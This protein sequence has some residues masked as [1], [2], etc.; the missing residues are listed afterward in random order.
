MS[1]LK[2][3]PTIG[4]V[5]LFGLAV[6]ASE[7]HPPSAR[8]VASAEA[9]ASKLGDLSSFRSIRRRYSVPGGQG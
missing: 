9:A 6:L 4:A 3:V 8:I 5:A 2:L 1:N 7:P